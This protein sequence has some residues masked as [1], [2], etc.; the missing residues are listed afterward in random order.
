MDDEWTTPVNLGHPINTDSYDSM[1]RISHDGSMLSF[2]SAR[3]GGVG[4]QDIWQAPII[5]VVDFNGDARVDGRDVLAMAACW[6]QDDPLCDIGPTAFGDGVVNVE[7]LVVLAEYIGQ[8][9]DDPTLV[10]HWALDEREGTFVTDS[11]G[12]NDATVVGNAMWQP[13]GGKIGGALAF[14]GVD[15]FVLAASPAGLVSGRFSVCVWIKGGAPGQAIVSPQGGVR[16]L[17][18]NAIDGSLMTSLSEGGRTVQ[19][20]FS[21]VVVTDGQWHRVLLV[22]DGTDRIL[23]VD[24]REAARE[25]LS[26]VSAP[27]GKLIIGGSGTLEPASLWSGLIDDVRIYRRTV[28]P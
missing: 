3:P 26:E 6:G 28:K 12:E 16:W 14:D 5:P 17:Y 13:E 18:T 7:D 11:A 1:P 4:N 27:G 21:D 10:A 15:D 9:V 2:C 24:G 23:C 8:E 19:P 20:L 22:W 25:P